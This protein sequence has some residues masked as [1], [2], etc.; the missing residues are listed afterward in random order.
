MIEAFG[1]RVTDTQGERRRSIQDFYASRYRQAVGSGVLRERPQTRPLARPSN[2]S[3]IA[4]TG[5][6]TAP[7]I[8]TLKNPR[9]SNHPQKP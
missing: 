1:G 2:G 8:L 3:A 6:I 4:A 9:I 5:G 7:P